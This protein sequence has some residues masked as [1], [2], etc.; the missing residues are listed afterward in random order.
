MRPRTKG[1]FKIN[2][3][4]TEVQELIDKIG[5]ICGEYRISTAIVALFAIAVS[6]AWQVSIP[7]INL[8]D[9]LLQVMYGERDEKIVR[10]R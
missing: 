10:Y 8:I 1:E 5:P 4:K 2:F 3:E 6:A 7:K 9:A